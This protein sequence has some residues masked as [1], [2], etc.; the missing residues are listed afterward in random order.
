MIKAE[1]IKNGDGVDVKTEV[2]GMG[3]DII[4]EALG[5]VKAIGEGLT[6]RNSDM[7]MMFTALVGNLTVEWIKEFTGEGDGRSDTYA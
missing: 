7:G 1:A 2:E 3:G 4:E 5:I 6:E